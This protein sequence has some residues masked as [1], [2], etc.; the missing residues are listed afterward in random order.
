MSRTGRRTGNRGRWSFLRPVCVVL[1]LTCV[2][3]GCKSRSDLVEAELR[4]REREVRDLRAAL[5]RSEMFNSA[6]TQPAAAPI[7]PFS[8]PPGY[9]GET[10]AP[11]TAVMSGTVKEVVLGRGTGGVD[12]DGIPGDETLVL[13][14]IPKDSDGSA[15]KVPGRLVVQVY[16]VTAEGQKVPFCHWVI[17]P[18]ELQKLWKNG[19]LATGYQVTLRWKTWPNSPKLRVVVQFTTVADNRMFE[20]ERDITIRLPSGAP[21]PGTVV[22]AP[23]PPGGVIESPPSYDGPM[24]NPGAWFRERDPAAWLTEARPMSQS[25]TSAKPVDR[26]P[27]RLL[28]PRTVV[29]E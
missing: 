28:E 26:E 24:L 11:S 12:N 22:P 8:P 21:R 23:S 15:L 5:Q 18:T 7:P 17:A 19:L 29:D 27:V 13:V 10:V 14:V 1:A 16:E 6:L 20:A 9:S 2:V 25:S 3:G 4:T